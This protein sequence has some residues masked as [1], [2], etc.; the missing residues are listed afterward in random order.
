MNWNLWMIHAEL[1]CHYNTSPY[2]H[3]NPVKRNKVVR[4]LGSGIIRKGT[5]KRPVG[6][7]LEPVWPL[8]R[9]TVSLTQPGTQKC[10]L[11]NSHKK[12]YPAFGKKP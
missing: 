6:Q 3:P 12:L 9:K 10:H 5:G 11:H 1:F 8:Q 7:L 4:E 2:S